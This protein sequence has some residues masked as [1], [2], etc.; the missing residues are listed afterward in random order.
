VEMSMSMSKVDVEVELP[1]K[2]GSFVS[3]SVGHA[4]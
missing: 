1:P 2:P 4:N 3:F